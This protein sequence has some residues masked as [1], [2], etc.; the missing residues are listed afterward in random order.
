MT[1]EHAAQAPPIPSRLAGKVA[2]IT[3]AASGMGLATAR[4]LT[5]EGAHVALVDIN[6]DAVSAAAEQVGGGSIA[7][8]ADVCEPEAVAVMVE[9]TVAEL[10]PIDVFHNNAGVAEAVT[11]VTEIPRGEWDRIV[12]VNLTAFFIGVQAVVPGMRAAG[13]G[14]IVLTGTIATRRPRAGLAAYVASKCGAVGLARQLAVELAPDAIRVNVV[15]PGPA[16]TP[17]L[18]E[19]RFGEDRDQVVSALSDALPLG[20]AI[21]SEDVA[22]AVAYLAS[23]DARSVTGVV[24]NVD[25]GRDL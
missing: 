13:G 9:R 25:A 22:A 21:E 19:F 1:A 10:G 7:I 4:R 2:L 5:A 24:L 23:E 16:L 11:P 20:R 8:A 14:S 12:R 15:N 6:G 17:M 18:D 3:G